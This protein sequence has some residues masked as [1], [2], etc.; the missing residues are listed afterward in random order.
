MKKSGLMACLMIAGSIISA[1]AINMSTVSVGKVGVQNYEIA[2][3]ATEGVSG[4]EDAITTVDVDVDNVNEGK[5]GGNVAYKNYTVCETSLVPISD[6]TYNIVTPDGEVIATY[7]TTPSDVSVYGTWRY[8]WS[9]E[10]DQ[11]VGSDDPVQSYNGF[12]MDFTMNFS[13]K[14]TS[15][16]GVMSNDSVF[17][18]VFDKNNSFNGTITFSKDIGKVALV[19]WNRSGHSI[20]YSGTL[21]Y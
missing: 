8:S 12:K 16:I 10:N 6:T 21:T 9:S 2:H 3:V 17:Y 7:D 4:C 18:K 19:V 15:E 14:G 5:I 20:T 13:S 11:I 1:S